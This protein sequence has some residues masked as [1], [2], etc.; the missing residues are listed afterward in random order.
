MKHQVLNHYTHISKKRYLVN[1]NYFLSQ[2][3]Y[4]YH[5]RLYVQ[6]IIIVCVACTKLWDSSSV[7]HQYQTNEQKVP[8]PY[9]YI[10]YVFYWHS[11]DS[12]PS[13]N[14]SLQDKRL[15]IRDHKITGQD[16][17]NC[18]IRNSILQEL[19]TKTVSILL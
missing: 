3:I 1:L 5:L 2:K 12:Y 15:E 4:K 19:H 17:I 9:M 11:Y 16:K 7:V 10:K 13:Y 18:K 8:T 6:L 14:P